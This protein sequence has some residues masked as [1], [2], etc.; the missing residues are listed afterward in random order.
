MSES[1]Q[2]EPS[3]R[4]LVAASYALPIIDGNS[5]HLAGTVS[6]QSPWEGDGGFQRLALYQ[7]RNVCFSTHF[8]RTGLH[9]IMVS[10]CYQNDSFSAV[11]SSSVVAVPQPQL[12][13]RAGLLCA[14][15][16]PRVPSLSCAGEGKA[17]CPDEISRATC[18]FC[19]HTCKELMF[20]IWA[21]E[22]YLLLPRVLI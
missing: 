9:A 5:S 16:F 2:A 10:D 13:P 21:R 15:G 6:L 3:F 12:V 22:D 19:P 17:L 18:A 4:L 8:S 7:V 11:K 1:P 20:P 14:G